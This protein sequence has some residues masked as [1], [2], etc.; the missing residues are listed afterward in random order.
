M[1]L[2]KIYIENFRCYKE[3]IAIDIEDLT[4]FIGKNDIGK[5]T[6]LDALEIFFNNETVKIDSKDCNIHSDSS[7]VK[8]ACDFTDLPCQLILDSGEKTSLS[9]EYLTLQEDTLCIKKFLTV[10]KR[11]HLRMFSL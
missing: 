1:K 10:V 2:K 9:A 11:S 3:Q 4:T 5:S 8:I 6:V 7:Q